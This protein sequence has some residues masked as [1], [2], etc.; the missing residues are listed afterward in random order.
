MKSQTKKKDTVNFDWNTDYIRRVISEEYNSVMTV[1]N[2]KHDPFFGWIVGDLMESQIKNFV[3][4]NY[5]SFNRKQLSE[6]LDAYN[7][8]ALSLLSEA[9][10]ELIHPP[11]KSDEESPEKGEKTTDLPFPDKPDDFSVHH[12]RIL[13]KKYEEKLDENAYL[14]HRDEPLELTKKIKKPEDQHQVKDTELEKE[15]FKK[16][17]VQRKKQKEI[18]RRRKEAGY[19]KPS[20][21]RIKKEGADLNENITQGDD[22]QVNIEFSLSQK[23]IFD[24][25]KYGALIIKEINQRGVIPIH[26]EHLR[27]MQ[28]KE[29]FLRFQLVYYGSVTDYFT[30]EMVRSEIMPDLEGYLAGRYLDVEM[31][32][33]IHHQDEMSVLFLIACFSLDAIKIKVPYGQELYFVRNDERFIEL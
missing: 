11:K 14:L 33:Q 21:N 16:E 8:M 13:R 17:L 5:S 19:P 6:S 3:L 22:I 20:N 31:E 32:I 9:F 30:E 25:R 15:K 4:E 23:D 29:G 24:I 7:H 26:K 1:Y 28:M 2:Q 18:Q 27:I 12:W 10:H